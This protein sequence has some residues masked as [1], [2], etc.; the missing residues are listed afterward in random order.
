M[1]RWMGLKLKIFEDESFRLR[2]FLQWTPNLYEAQE[3]VVKIIFHKSRSL[4]SFHQWV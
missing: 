3:I 2:A 1:E 4:M